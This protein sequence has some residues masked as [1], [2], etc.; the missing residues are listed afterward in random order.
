V[1]VPA[2]AAAPLS[3]SNIVLAAPSGTLTAPKD[4]L[5]P[6]L[7]IV[8][9]ARRDFA[10]TDRFAAFFRIYQGSDRQDPLVPVQLQSTVVDAGDR[11]VATETRTLD[12]GQFANGRAADYYV[13]L[14]L[15]TLAPGDY[16]LKVEAKMA[17]R[18][19]GRA[20]RFV[21]H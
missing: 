19:A 1:T 17:P 15:A 16:L 18:V 9:T 13:V 6:V 11:V 7:P 20:I 8:P 14:P 21:V 4:F 5:S 12:A 2:F 3:L 10:R